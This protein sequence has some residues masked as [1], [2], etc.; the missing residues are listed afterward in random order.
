MNDGHLMDAL[1][2]A[3]PLRILEIRDWSPRQR[4]NDA[5]WYGNLLASGG[6]ALQYGSGRRGEV[7]ATFRNL[8]Y[9]LA[10]LAYAPGGVTVNGVHWCAEPHAECP[11]ARY[12]QLGGRRDPS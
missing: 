3:V 4:D 8:V 12:A 2:A 9:G 7:A 6:D 10:C 5:K 11:N 1:Q